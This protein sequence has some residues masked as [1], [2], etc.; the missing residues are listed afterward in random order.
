MSNGN[1]H[2]T[3][4]TRDVA[5]EVSRLK[6]DINHVA[7]EVRGVSNNIHILQAELLAQIAVTIDR[8][9]AV[10]NEVSRSIEAAAQAKIVETASEIF[11]KIGIIT[12][13]AKR[14]SQQYHKSV[15]RCGRISEKFDRL[16]D[17]VTESYH[18]DIHRL[19]KHIFDIRN[20]HYQKVEDRIQKQ[21][22]GF[23]TT[24]KR[25]VEQIRKYREQKLEELL[26]A[27]KEKL[28][29][30][31]AQRQNFHQ[32]ISMITA[33]KLDAPVDKIAIPMIIVKK[34]GTSTA[35]IKIGHEVVPEEN[36]YI[37]YCLK[38]TDIFKTYRSN[39]ANLDRHTHWR[40]MTAAELK[41]LEHNLGKLLE[42]NLLSKEYHKLLVQGLK[43]S[44]PKVTGEFELS[45]TG[46][47]VSTSLH[48]DLERTGNRQVEI[49]LE[50]E[51]LIVDGIEEEQG[52]EEEIKELEEDVKRSEIRLDFDDDEEEEED[53]ES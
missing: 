5:D 8:I 3:V 7:S 47:E 25:S 19:G 17:E 9:N 51:A 20:N 24:I 50:E 37:G 49:N 4:D 40:N 38:E 22:T 44:P 36:K 13:S 11:G 16:N 43:K 33:R 31:L 12:S 26:K 46:D 1:I 45:R 21:H 27:V 28:A 15:I 32:S 2:V 35:Q 53:I 23:L 29:H 42:T 52:E 30:F 14:I 39:C 10:R 48:T 41:L 34:T 6:N 18:T